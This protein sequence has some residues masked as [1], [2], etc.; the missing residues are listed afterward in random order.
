MALCPWSASSN[1]PCLELYQNPQSLFEHV[2]FVHLLNSPEIIHSCRWPGCDV[3]CDSVEQLLQHFDEHSFS[4]LVALQQRISSH[5]SS[6]TPPTRDHSSSLYPAPS[7]PLSGAYTSSS[8]SF[9]QLRVNNHLYSTS[10][11]PLHPPPDYSFSPSY[12]PSPAS[13]HLPLPRLSSNPSYSIPPT[14][15][16]A[17]P[18][19]SLSPFALPFLPE[20]SASTRPATGGG[21]PR[22]QCHW[23]DDDGLLIHLEAVHLVRRFEY[24]SKWRCGWGD[25]QSKFDTRQHLFDHLAFA[26]LELFLHV[27][28]DCTPPKQFPRSAG[29]EKHRRN[30]H[31]P[32][33]SSIQPPPSL[34][35]SF[36]P[37]SATLAIPPVPYYAMPSQ[38]GPIPAGS[39]PRTFPLI[40]P[41]GFYSPR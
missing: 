22:H 34:E 21:G 41:R 20:V 4:R 33:S 12:Q 1:S 11:F 32:S 6:F 5:Q 26:H 23:N 15:N 25:C 3:E 14:R 2:H 8:S 7:L 17:F 36:T 28:N 30:V 31:E 19:L 37:P 9:S 27:C 40:S 35:Q 39:R 38:A 13:P 10:T 24:E 16:A 18:P 29:L